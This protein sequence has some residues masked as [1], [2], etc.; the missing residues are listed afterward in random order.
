MLP[1]R[2]SQF[3]QTDVEA[4]I[5]APQGCSE[6]ARLSALE[7]QEEKTTSADH[8]WELISCPVLETSAVLERAQ[9]WSDG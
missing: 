8:H 2:P 1:I 6:A 5:S 7:V 4:L 3:L 9:A